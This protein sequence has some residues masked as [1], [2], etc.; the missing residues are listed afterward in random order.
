MYP[1]GLQRIT[2]GASESRS[3]M[4]SSFSDADRKMMI[5]HFSFHANCTINHM[6]QA[7]RWPRH[8]SALALCTPAT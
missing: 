6:L 8:S 1:H 3:Q 4:H 7:R 5:L 2:G